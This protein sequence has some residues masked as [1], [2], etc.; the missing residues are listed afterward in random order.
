VSRPTFL[1]VPRFALSLV[2]GEFA[3]SS[4]LAGQRA[5]P[6]VLEGAGFD[7]THRTLDDALRAALARE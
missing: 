3:R 4:V 2:L 5:M 7:F 1:T 6:T